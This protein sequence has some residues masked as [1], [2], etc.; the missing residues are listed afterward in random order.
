MIPQENPTV[1]PTFHQIL[2]SKCF[3][4]MGLVAGSSLHKVRQPRDVP[5]FSSALHILET[6][7]WVF[8]EVHAEI[9][10]WLR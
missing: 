2:K 4:I 9:A 3:R 8:R 10:F 7:A 6:L 5:Q 1:D